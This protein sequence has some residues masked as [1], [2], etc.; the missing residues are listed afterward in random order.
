MLLTCSL[1]KACGKVVDLEPADPVFDPSFNFTHTECGSNRTYITSSGDT[2]NSISSAKN[3]SSSSLF[4]INTNLLDCDDIPAETE[5]CLP[6][7]CGALW[8]VQEAETCFDIKSSWGLTTD[9]LLDWNAGLNCSKLHTGLWG[10]TLCV[11]PPGGDYIS[12]T[13][14]TGSLDPWDYGDGYLDDVVDPP[15]NAMIADGTTL[16]CGGW[17]VAEEDVACVDICMEEKVVFSLFIDVNP[18]LRNGTCDSDLVVGNTYCVHP[19]STWNETLTDPSTSPP[20]TSG[21]TSLPSQTATFNV[22]FST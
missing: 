8:T 16:N 4:W 9:V 3:V 22:A 18:S 17:Y 12:N 5:L 1:E 13:N 7:S 20:P 19:A 2:C 6:Q 21:A 11:L 15:E 10:N 14:S